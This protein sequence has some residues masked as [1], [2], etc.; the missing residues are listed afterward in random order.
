MLS[1]K[2]KKSKKY[3]LRVSK[4]PVGSVKVKD[5]KKYIKHE[6]GWRLMK[7]E[8]Y[9]PGEVKELLEKGRK[10]YDVGTI[11]EW[12]GSRYR[13]TAPGKWT[14]LYGDKTRKE[15]KAEKEGDKV[16]GEENKED[17]VPY[18]PGDKIEVEVYDARTK[19]IKWHSGV[20]KQAVSS[21]DS[22]PFRAD[23]K[24]DDGR[25]YSEA[26][27]SSIRKPQGENKNVK[28]SLDERI[29]S[30]ED[31]KERSLIDVQKDIIIIGKANEEMHKMGDAIKE[32]TGRGLNRE[33]RDGLQTK[34][35]SDP[36]VKGA[37]DRLKNG[38]SDNTK[39][40]LKEKY[41]TFNPNYIYKDNKKQIHK[42]AG[43]KIKRGPRKVKAEPVKE[44]DELI[45]AEK[46][47][48]LFHSLK[49]KY[50]ERLAELEKDKKL[51]SEEKKAL[52][53]E[54][55]T[56]EL[57][58]KL[59]DFMKYGDKMELIREKYGKGKYG[60]NT[61]SADIWKKHKKK[62]MKK[63]GEKDSSSKSKK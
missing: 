24:L 8:V 52:S 7:S 54:I 62:L 22:G 6:K 59:N 23:V 40:Q 20:F 26:A 27:A 5:G 63:Y 16:K 21:T 17:K 28:N 10:G 12:K 53:N 56:P 48:V 18:E 44:S 14:K 49:D 41:G 29:S 57:R 32:K 61:F 38:M 36:I 39:E 1:V 35:L 19:T 42:E 33:E 58:E 13:K 45:D 50:D 51:S 43:E 60:G 46:D 37:Y 25:E 11:R 2:V 9:S 15:V 47:L 30:D 31:K 4:S 3:K 55:L 34:I